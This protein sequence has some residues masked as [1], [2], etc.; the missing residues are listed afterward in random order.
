M[1][2]IFKLVLLFSILIV[3][4]LSYKEKNSNDNNFG[5]Y[6]VD[7]D[8]MSPTLK[9][10]DI[11]ITRPFDSYSSNDIV[12]FMY[13]FNMTQTITHRIIGYE[14]E[15]TT[16]FITKGDKNTTVDPW[17]LSD[18]LIKG[19]VVFSIPFLG[20]LI[21]FIRTPVGLLLFVVLPLGLN[22]I[23]EG[24]SLIKESR[25]FWIMFKRRNSFKVNKLKW[26]LKKRLAVQ[27]QNRESSV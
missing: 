3:C 27:N 5:F 1:K 24:D 21:K 8:S 14:N 23:L 15:E 17:N 26:K 10:G 25:L 6:L 4:F 12:T 19:K 18:E 22:I 13:P 20:H 11:V 7:S 16:S 9:K 2:L